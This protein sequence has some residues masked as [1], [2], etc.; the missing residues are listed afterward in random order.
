M[1][2]VNPAFGEATG[3]GER[4]ALDTVD[5]RSV[6]VA[7]VSNSKPNARE[8]LEGVQAQLATV[9][10]VENFGHVAKM[11]ASQP[12]PQSVIDEVAEGYQAALLAI[13]D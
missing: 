6:P 10:N 7:L 5:W 12:A 11:S 8:L 9:R 3:G 4:R 13:A 2:I 1:L